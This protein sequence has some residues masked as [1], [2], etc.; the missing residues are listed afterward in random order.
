ML[1]LR[2]FGVQGVLEIKNLIFFIFLQ[3]AKFQDF[4]I[5]TLRILKGFENFNLR[6]LPVLQNFKFEGFYIY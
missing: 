5:F 3:N 4:E 1:D 2:V 6:V